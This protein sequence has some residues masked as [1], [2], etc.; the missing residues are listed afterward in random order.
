M[1]TNSEFKVPRQYSLVVFDTDSISE[2]A[3]EEYYGETFP[4]G[5]TFIFL[6]EV[7]NARGHCVLADPET[8]KIICL[9]HTFNFREATDDET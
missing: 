9:Y 2:K 5:K 4:R 3:Y 8:G 7:P 1:K 6:G